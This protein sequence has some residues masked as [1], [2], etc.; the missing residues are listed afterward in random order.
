MKKWLIT[1]AAALLLQVSAGAAETFTFKGSGEPT[2]TAKELPNGMQFKGFEGKPVVLNFFGKECP[3]CRREI[4]HLIALKKRY[5]DKIG[6]IGVHVQERMTPK[7]RAAF[8]FDYPV[9]EYEDN[10]AI[11]R[12]IGGRAGYNGSIPFNI[13][14]KADGEVAGII[15]G[16]VKGKQLEAIFTDLLKH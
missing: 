12:H 10:M 6:V 7:E 15:P 5:G 9:Y 4:P 14:F 13:F 2:I 8:N 11:I 1:M 3:Y 16:M